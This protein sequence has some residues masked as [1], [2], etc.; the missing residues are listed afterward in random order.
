MQEPSESELLEDAVL[1]QKHKTRCEQVAL[2]Q[3]HLTPEATLAE[4]RARYRELTV[5]HH[6]DKQARLESTQPS[7]SLTEFSLAY[8]RLR[9]LFPL[10]PERTAEP[11]PA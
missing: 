6:P 1:C 8:K 2:F 7:T 11:N 4:I 9:E 5:K 10:P 3:L